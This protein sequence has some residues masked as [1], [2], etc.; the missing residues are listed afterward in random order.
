MQIDLVS[1]IKMLM[2]GSNCWD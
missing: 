1:V 2:N